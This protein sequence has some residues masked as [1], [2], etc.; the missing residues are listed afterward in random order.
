MAKCQFSFNQ[1]KKG[2][3]TEIS[4]LIWKQKSEAHNFA[5]RWDKD[6]NLN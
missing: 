2:K 6:Y 5:G 1:G 4:V 3:E